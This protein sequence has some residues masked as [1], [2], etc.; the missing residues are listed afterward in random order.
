MAPSDLADRL[1]FLFPTTYCPGGTTT[2]APD[3]GDHDAIRELVS[4][5]LRLPTAANEAEA[6]ALSTFVDLRAFF[7]YAVLRDTAGAWQA[8]LRLLDEGHDRDEVLEQI[9]DVLGEHVLEP[10]T[11][12]EEIDVERVNAAFDRLGRWDPIDEELEHLP[13][14][15]DE[16]RSSGSVA[17]DEIARIVR[18]VIHPDVLDVIGDAVRAVEEVAA[19]FSG[20]L[21]L[22]RADASA[23]IGMY[24]EWFTN[25][26]IVTP[27]G[28]VARSATVLDGLRFRHVL[29]EAE[30]DNERVEVGTDLAVVFDGI[31]DLRFPDG[32]S[33]QSTY[34]TAVDGPESR[35][36]EVHVVDGPPGW[37]GG[38]RAGDQ[39]AISR[40][41]DQIT[42][43]GVEPAEASAHI[44]SALRHARDELS[45]P[46]DVYRLMGVAAV[47]AGGFGSDLGA[48][49]SGLLELT[50]WSARG[51]ELA[52]AGYDWDAVEAERGRRGRAS[53]LD[54]A[55]VDPAF[56]TQVERL[57]DELF[58]PGNWFHSTDARP[59]QDERVASVARLLGREGVAGAVWTLGVGP[60]PDET[61][62]RAVLSLAQG[63][64][65]RCRPA[66]AT[67][68]ARLALLAA[69]TLDRVDLLPDLI[70]LGAIDDSCDP[71]LCSIAADVAIDQ[72][73][74]ATAR[75]HQQR[76]WLSPGELL[77][78]VDRLDHPEQS[79]SAGR[80]DPCPCG[81]GQKFKRCHGDPQPRTP[82]D[83]ERAQLLAT[84]LDQHAFRRL[85]FT[86]R[87]AKRA[88]LLE[89]DE[90]WVDGGELAQPFLRAVTWFAGGVLEDHL[91]SRGGLLPDA[92]RELE[93]SWAGA[94]LV[95]GTS[96]TAGQITLDDGRILPAPRIGGSLVLPF[97]P[98]VGWEV[99]VGGE[100]AFLFGAPVGPDVDVVAAQ[101][102][103]ARGPDAIADVLG[104]TW[105]RRAVC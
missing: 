44:V 32:S 26:V 65:D 25:A 4:L 71:A 96:S 59:V 101:F 37:L 29:T 10:M 85:R 99:P 62:A 61:A 41:G 19:P 33:I 63:L 17:D 90:W 18:E 81:S 75:Q 88:G 70:R 47:D 105:P 5:E 86:H 22:P 35:R 83:E 55:G 38:A 20:R 50:G 103:A 84:R 73:D 79:F 100:P 91:A 102:S 53:V 68:P 11:S 36:G 15:I 95:V 14:M 74:I 9:N 49:L 6:R 7:A 78:Q 48:P 3:V 23:V 92:D 104:S 2:D 42:V 67:G 27:R 40:H 66:H 28:N 58:G 77:R 89:D 31:D 98:M 69:G 43:E 54:A 34:R 46:T 56:T 8:V 72:G 39:I 80:N 21:R 57:V 60:D 97:G 52:A 30:A 76:G 64:L 51:D 13:W 12:G 24:L 94:R 1:A 93:E 45:L 82:T 87:L 16:W